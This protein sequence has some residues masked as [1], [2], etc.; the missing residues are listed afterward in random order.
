MMR[1]LY[2]MAAVM[3]GCMCLMPA[4]GAD[5]MNG[6]FAPRF[7]SLQVTVDGD[8]QSLPVV[9]LNG[10]DRIT[11]SFDEIAEDREYYQYSLVHCNADWQPSGL[12]DS[13]FLDGFNVGQVDDYRFSEATTVH[14]VHYRITLPNEEMRITASGNYL[15]KVYPENE[16]DNVVVQ[17]RF[18]VTEYSMKVSGSVTSRTDIDY[19]D[20]HQQLSIIVDTDNFRPNDIYNDI[21]VV[22]TQNGRE[23][24]K[25]VLGQPLRVSGNRAY[26]E[27]Q[28]PLIFDAGNEYRRM[29]TVSMTYPGM[30]VADIVYAAPYYH[31]QIQT[32]LPRAKENYSF[33][34]TQF[35]RYKIREY[36][37]DDSDVGADYAMTHFS[38]EMPQ[39]E[40]YDIFLDGDFTGR[41]F[42]PES[43]MYYNAVTHRYETSLLLK[44]G[45]YNYQYL[46]VPS[47]SMR[48]LTSVVEGDFYP[49]VNEY[50]VKVYCR[51]PGERYDRL[52]AV[53]VVYSGR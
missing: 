52:T 35:G 14:Y 47:G 11:I 53:T 31:Q 10:E 39:L 23:D 7:R 45:A 42:N 40:D 34:R 9:A 29:E 16:P 21:K 44:Q 17:A 30:R 33:D 6:T 4:N 3:S 20:K 26:Y 8:E 32:D 36:N 18:S 1:R 43:R 15:L 5:T 37:S 38:L 41:R 46:A 12:V 51:R 19:N 25:V 13:E 24:N 28:R 27:H 48:G 22:V 50:A 49:T 2:V